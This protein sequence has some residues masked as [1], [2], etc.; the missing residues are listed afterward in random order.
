MRILNYFFKGKT[1]KGSSALEDRTLGAGQGVGRINKTDLSSHLAG[2]IM[3]GQ[4]F[5]ATYLNTKTA[6]ISKRKMRLSLI[7]FVALGSM[8]CLYLI[9]SA[10]LLFLK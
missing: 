8:Y 10:V 4:R 2:E 3:K 1:A 7:C 6:G 9:L 5:V